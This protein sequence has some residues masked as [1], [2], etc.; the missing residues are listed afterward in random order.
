M[1]HLRFNLQSL[2]GKQYT[3][4]TVDKFGSRW[5]NYKDNDRAFV[6]DQEIKQK[7]PHEHFLKDDHHGFEKNVSICLTDKTQFSDPQKR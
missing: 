4:K 7:F 3:G 5:N 1:P 2:C 6:R